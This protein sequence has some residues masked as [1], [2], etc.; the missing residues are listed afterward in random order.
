[1]AASVSGKVTGRS[2]RQSTET[3]LPRTERRRTPGS[4]QP[5]LERFCVGFSPIDNPLRRWVEE[6]PTI[7]LTD[8][9]VMAAKAAC[10]WTEGSSGILQCSRLIETL[11]HPPHLFNGTEVRAIGGPTKIGAGNCDAD[12]IVCFFRPLCSMG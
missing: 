3:D 11:S 6:L 10:A 9:I 12:C 1:V 2:T 8:D 4:P 7:P 5:S